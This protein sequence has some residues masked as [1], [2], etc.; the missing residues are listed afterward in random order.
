M[1]FDGGCVPRVFTTDSSAKALPIAPLGWRPL[2]FMSVSLSARAQN[3][4]LRSNRHRYRSA[5]SRAR[6]KIFR[7]MSLVSLPV[8]VFWL[9]G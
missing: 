5:S 6:M 1:A 2:H 3:I 8:W 7:N 4:Q 9:E